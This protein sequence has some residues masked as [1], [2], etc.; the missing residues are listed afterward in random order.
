MV[1]EP[2]RCNKASTPYEILIMKP[3]LEGWSTKA[4]EIPSPNEVR[5]TSLDT[6][7]AF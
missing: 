5:L 7:P 3:S 1:C 6:N 4:K 2:G